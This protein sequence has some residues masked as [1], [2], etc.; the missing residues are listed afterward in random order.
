MVHL[1][2]AGSME[3]AYKMD[4]FTYFKEQGVTLTPLG[5]NVTFTIK[6][7]MTIVRG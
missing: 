3:V 6:V 2:M 1:Q 7:F 4:M 5:I